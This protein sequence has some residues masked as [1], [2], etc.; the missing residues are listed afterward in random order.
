MKKIIASL[1]LITSLISCTSDDESTITQPQETNYATGYFVTNEGNFQTNNADVSFLSIDLLNSENQIFKKANNRNIGDVAQSM[2][3]NTNYVFVVMNNS[4]TIEVVNKKT[5]KSVFT[6]TEHLQQPR[7]ATITN[8]KLWVTNAGNNTITSYN[9]SDFSPSETISLNFTPELIDST[10]D[11]IYVTTNPWAETHQIVSYST[12][13]HQPLLTTT[14]NVP[15]N[16]LVKKNNLLYA[17]ASSEDITQIY[18]I[19]SHYSYIVTENN[20][21]NSRFL[22]IEGDKLYYTTGIR[23]NQFDM[24]SQ[25]SSTLFSVANTGWS[26]IYGFNVFDDQIFI[27]DAKNFSEAGEVNVYNLSGQKTKSLKVGIGPN[28]IYKIQ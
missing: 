10:T 1:A 16:G 19:T 27:L 8:D 17:L 23:I 9:L 12:N 20:D 6:I 4:N 26:A 24:T 21:V 18:E 13:T 15:V 11:Y 25:T 5:F 7:Y 14:L 3:Q 2:T 28:A 22:S